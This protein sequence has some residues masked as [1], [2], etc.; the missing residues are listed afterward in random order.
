MKELSQ[1]AFKAYDSEQRFRATFEQAAVGIALVAP[2]GRW[3]RVN[4]K[5]CEI[6][7]YSHDELMTKTFQDITYPDDLNADLTFVQQMLAG[8]IDS[9]SMEKR[10]ICKDGSIVWINLSVAL[11]RNPDATPDYFISVVENIQKRKQSEAAL[12]ESTAT[13]KEA[14]QL[15]G[16]GN[17]RWDVKNDVHTW[18]EEIYLIYGRD[19]SLPPAVYPEVQQYFTPES[20][21]KLCRSRGKRSG[22]RCCL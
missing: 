19:P 20:W 14:Q 18:S 22:S 13:L 10:Y 17:W 6:I 12:L 15:A 2:D 7:G 5:L 1:S 3:L 4:N 21:T 16:I 11:T 8:E 9:Y